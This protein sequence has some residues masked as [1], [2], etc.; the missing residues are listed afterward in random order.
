MHTNR[1]YVIVAWVPYNFMLD[2]YKPCLLKLYRRL[3][4]M[5]SE[6]S[7]SNASLAPVKSIMGLELTAAYYLH[8]NA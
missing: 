1:N 3:E 4:L 8:D 7:H 6:Q 2:N 5:A